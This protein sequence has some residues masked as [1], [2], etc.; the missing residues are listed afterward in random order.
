MLGAD[1]IRDK[2]VASLFRSAPQ[3]L[4]TST[5]FTVLAITTKLVAASPDTMR[6]SV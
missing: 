4:T 2:R 1:V 3:L 6:N 5:I